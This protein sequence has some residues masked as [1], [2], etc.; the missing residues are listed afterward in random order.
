MK[1]QALRNLPIS[2]H[3]A[4]PQRVKDY[5]LE[6]HGIDWDSCFDPCPLNSKFDG[7]KISWKKQNCINPPYSDIENFMIKSYT[8]YLEGKEN[9]ILFPIS[10]SDKWYFRTFLEQFKKDFIYIPFRIQFVGSENPAFQ[11]HVLVVMK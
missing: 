1:L 9:Y 3:H 4:T 10:K 6:N 11:T 5:L 7:L 8:E 2:D